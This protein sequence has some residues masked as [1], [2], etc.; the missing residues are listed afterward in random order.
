VIPIGVDRRSKGETN[1]AE[2]PDVDGT[3]EMTRESLRE[4]C[5]A[6]WPGEEVED[7]GLLAL[8]VSALATGVEERCGSAGD[9]PDSVVLTVAVSENVGSMLSL[10]P[11]DGAEEDLCG[12]LRP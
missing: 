4:G 8:G 12:S 9:S 6:C 5:F 10:K 11:G 7:E 1:S 2:D 3:G